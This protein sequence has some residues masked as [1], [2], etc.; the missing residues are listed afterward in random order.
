MRCRIVPLREVDGRDEHAWLQLATCVA[1]PNP[2]MEPD[3]L[4]PGA[5]HQAFGGELEITFA[6]EGD[7]F[8]GCM[9]LRP[10]LQDDRPGGDDSSYPQ[11]AASTAVG[12]CSGRYKFG[13]ARFVKGDPK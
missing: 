8:Y 11:P 9:P 13:D 1:E 7:R 10:V 5:R 4:L 6:E 2:L 12:F 3:C